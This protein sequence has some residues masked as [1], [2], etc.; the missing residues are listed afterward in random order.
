MK[1]LNHNNSKPS[2][3]VNMFTNISEGVKSTILKPRLDSV[4]Q[5]ALSR[6]LHHPHEINRDRQETETMK[7]Q[8]STRMT[9]REPDVIPDESEIEVLLQIMEQYFDFLDAFDFNSCASGSTVLI[10]ADEFTLSL[11]LEGLPQLSQ[12]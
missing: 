5:R 4:A 11:P 6:V 3:F 12:F 1:D 7:S 2:H 10:V 8:R 9:N